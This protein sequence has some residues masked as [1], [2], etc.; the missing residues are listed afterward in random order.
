MRQ[1]GGYVTVCSEA[2]VGTRLSVYLP[3]A[4]GTVAAAP[5]PRRPMAAQDT[6]ETILVVDDDASVLAAAA[7]ILA[8]AGYEVLP[9]AS[10]EEAE[11]I[12]SA[13]GGDIHLLMT[14][15][16]MPQMN[17]GELARRVQRTRP[18]IRVLYTSGYTSDAVIGRGFITSDTVFLAKP[19][20]LADVVAKVREALD[21]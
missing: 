18:A 12:S 6:A 17:G 15:V 4:E 16:M 1:S 3:R 13:F 2:G 9:A 19:F 7:R 5:L 11:A 21:G 8:R 14:D 10:P 20:N